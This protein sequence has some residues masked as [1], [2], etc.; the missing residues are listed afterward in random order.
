[1]KFPEDY[2]AEELKGKD[3]TFKIKLHQIKR[4]ELPTLDDE[5]AKDVSEFDTLDEYKNSLR[6][7]PVTLCAV[8]GERYFGDK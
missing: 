7:K 4:K 1:M 6:E 8:P 2:Q 5:F 3:A